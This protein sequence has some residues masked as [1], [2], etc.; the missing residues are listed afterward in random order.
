MFGDGSVTARTLV[1]FNSDRRWLKTVAYELHRLTDSDRRRPRIIPPGARGVP[2]LEYSKSALFRLLMGPSSARLRSV[3]IL[4]RNRTLLAAFTAG[5]FDCEGSA[6]IYT[7]KRHPRGTVEISIANADVELL[8]LLQTRLRQQD[9]DG[10]ISLSAGPKESVI[11][12][13]TVKSRKTTY[14]LRFSGW[15]SATNFAKFILPWVKSR[16][17]ATRL[18]RIARR[19]GEWG[20]WD[21]NPRSPAFS[22]RFGPQAHRHE[23]LVS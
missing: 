21:L 23:A 8:R 7:N 9:I 3:A 22:P 2:S 4:T 17:K 11:G 15:S 18:K 6:T 13:R 5:I 14:R 19:R 16:S 20:R 12:K 10:G 1:Y